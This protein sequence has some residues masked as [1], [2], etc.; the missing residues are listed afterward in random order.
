[1]IFTQLF[2]K[3]VHST[4]TLNTVTSTNPQKIFKVQ[5]LCVNQPLTKELS[6]RH[7]NATTFT[8]RVMS[9][10]EAAVHLVPA[11]PKRAARILDLVTSG[12]APPTGSRPRPPSLRRIRPL[13]SA[14]AIDDLKGAES[15]PALTSSAQVSKNWHKFAGRADQLDLTGFGFF[16]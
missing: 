4:Q 2:N 11:G 15:V 5:N 14:P 10:S 8:W 16:F 1:M 12:Q 3:R 6:E 9:D 13:T 7:L